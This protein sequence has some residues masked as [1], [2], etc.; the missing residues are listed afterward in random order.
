AA[1]MLANGRHGELEKHLRHATMLM[2]DDLHLLFDRACY[3]EALGLP[4]YQVLPD[5]PSFFSSSGRFI[6]V[7][8]EQKTNGEAERLFRRALEIDPTLAE[9][10]VRLARLLDH[11]G[12]HD[13]AAAEIDKALTASP[14]RVAAYFAYLVGGRVAVARARYDEA[15]GQ[16]REAVSLIPTQS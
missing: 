16:Y 14:P 6:T 1:Y 5:D 8:S 12:Q 9:A 13:E 11:R 2:P 7:P 10:R 15:L 4:F 3:A